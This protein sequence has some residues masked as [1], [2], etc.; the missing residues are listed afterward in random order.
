MRHFSSRAFHWRPGAVVETRFVD[1]IKF[2]AQKSRRQ[3]SIETSLF[4][5][6]DAMHK[7]NLCIGRC[8]SVC[9]S[10]SCIQTA[11]DIV[12]LLSRPGSPILVFNPMRRY[13][14]PRGTPSVAVSNTP[15][16]G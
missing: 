3:Y 2:I 11:E 16:V 1:D 13:Q 5:L 10:R 4:L 7:R 9:L 8:P 14:I 6:R 12:K 15:G